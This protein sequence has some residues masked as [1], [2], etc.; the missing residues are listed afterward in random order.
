MAAVHEEEH[1]ARSV[2]R[3]RT[4]SG[5]VV[6][7]GFLVDAD[8]VATC[9]HV[10][11]EA[12]GESGVPATPPD[13]PVHLDFPLHGGARARATVLTWRERDDIALLRLDAPVPGSRPVP[14][15]DAG[16]A[17]VWQHPFR[18]LGF[19]AHSDGGVWA[20]GTLRGPQGEGWVQMETAL[21]GQRI[22]PG[23]SGTPV[24]DETLGGVAGMTVAA[25]GA[26]GSTTA[27]LVP[28]GTLLDPAV[29]PPRNPFRGLAPFAEADAGVFHGREEETRNLLAA[30]ARR[31]LTLVV[32]P[33]GSGKSSLVRAG[34][35]PALRAA[36]TTVRELRAVP[37]TRPAAALAHALAPVLE[38]ELGELARLRRTAEL[39]RLLDSADGLPA[40]VRDR[41][42]AHAGEGG[43][44]LFVD[45][46]EEY[47]TAD[48]AAARAL[49]RLLVALGAGQP[50][51]PALR[52][53]A[54]AR[55]ESLGVLVTPEAADVLSDA[56]R[57][58]APLSAEGLL[59]AVTGPVAALPGLWFEPGLPERI[60]A[61]AGEEPGRMPLVQFALTRLWEAREAGTL[62]HA[63]YDAVG[64]VAGAL[65]G[66]AEEALA[67]LLRPGE[68]PLARRLFVQLAR[69]AAGGSFARR[70]ARTAELAPALAEL[71]RRLA[72]TKLVVL[73]TA[74]GEDPGRTGPAAETVELAHESL[75]TLWPRL[76]DWLTESRDFRAWQE[77]LRRDLTRWRDQDREPAALLRGSSLATALDRLA[78]HPED[79]GE[80]ERAYI[81]LGDRQARRGTRRLYAVIAFVAALA[82]TAGGLAG[83]A[84][85]NNARYQGQLREQAG[86]LLAATAERREAAEPASALQLAL[87]ARATDPSPDTYGAL[88]RQYARGQSLT[89]SHPGL[90]PGAFESMDVTPDG[91]TAVVVSMRDDGTRAVS[92]VTGLDGD[93]PR[94]R[95]LRQVPAEALEDA[96]H[97]STSELG[98]DGRTFALAAGDGRVWLWDLPGAGPDARPRVLTSADAAGRRVNGV[99]LDI[100]SDGRRLLRMLAFYDG[101]GAKSARDRYAALSAWDLTTGRRLPTAPGLLPG[102]PRYAAFTADP[103]QVV[104][105]PDEEGGKTVVRELATGREVRSFDADY[106]NGTIAAGGERLVVGGRPSDPEGT[107]LRSFTTSGAPG[108]PVLLPPEVEGVVDPDRSGGFAV[109]AQNLEKGRRAEVTL[110]ELRT[111]HLYRTRLPVPGAA[112]A[113][114]LDRSVAVVPDG[115]DARVLLPAGDTLLTARAAPLAAL[116]GHTATSELVKGGPSP[117]GTLLARSGEG[118]VEVVETA[119]GRGRRAPAQPGVDGVPFWTADSRWIVLGLADATVSAFSAADPRRRVDLDLGAWGTGARAV[120]A[121]EPLT[122]SEVAVLTSDGRLMLFDA[123]TGRRLAP[124]VRAEERTEAERSDLFLATGQVRARPGRPDEA[125]VVVGTGTEAGRVEL[126]NLRDGVRLRTLTLGALGYA[127]ELGGLPRLQFSAD[128]RTLAALHGDGFVRFWDVETGRRTGRPLATADRFTRL[129]GFGPDGVF[130][131]TGPDGDPR[132]WDLGTGL[133]LADLPLPAGLGISLQGS[134][135]LAAGDG[136]H[137]AVD[138]RPEEMAKA[139]CRSGLDRDFTEAERALLPE[140][141]E[142]GPP[143]RTVGG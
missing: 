142:G 136:W 56:T 48:P 22:V 92:V 6:G 77:Q 91:R 112:S 137:Q 5:Q 1:L 143:C 102:D 59:R 54:T 24:W 45:Q 109:L 139:L 67:E 126:W 15:A 76:H 81:L 49:T 120:E 47:A 13:G 90:W 17:R 52:V 16:G 88:L 98:P 78:R 131:T 70:P 44:V 117:D 62:T 58:L 20:T 51:R 105:L 61:D 8:T 115:R 100:S 135:L 11:A 53:V 108:R 65:V 103:G 10:V 129:I 93:G 34:L 87:A 141:A 140:G 55:A 79:V 72:P 89:G 63:A 42:L 104:L 21:P 7:A 41:V 132:V 26:A 69:P 86:R 36:G 28:L 73:G 38:P 110:V 130:L 46:L 134:R 40:A 124:V 83:W 64:G 99:H 85:Y 96:G 31:P 37:G 118:F 128:G 57:L 106:R 84:L 75:T 30:A 60:V 68:E 111:G 29:L 33:S 114:D 119:T 32:G 39:T 50:G 71:A 3:V 74:G 9:A 138:L 133:L 82:L 25:D 94:S 14:P 43:H 18:A 113:T 107:P 123:A 35:L 23:F 101:K 12:A 66:Y 27:Y 4:R 80:A 97:G 2:V 116:P 122:G 95:P 19:P 125:A 127:S 121:I